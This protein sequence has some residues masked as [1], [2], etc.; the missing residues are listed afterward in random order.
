[1]AKQVIKGHDYLFVYAK[2]ISKFIPLGK[3]KDIRGKSS[4]EMEKNI[5]FRRTGSEKNLVNM[6]I[7]TMKRF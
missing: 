1:M 7:V 6:E 4:N 3:P 2:N 5:G